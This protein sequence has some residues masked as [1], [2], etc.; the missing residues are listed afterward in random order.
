MY[1]VVLGGVDA[2]IRT[3]N[4]VTCAEVFADDPHYPANAV[5]SFL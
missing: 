1:G 5:Q 3:E 2:A 4:N